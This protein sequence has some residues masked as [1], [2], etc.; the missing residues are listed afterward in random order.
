MAAKALF[1]GLI[2]DQSGN[3]V[4]TNF[5]GQDATYV[6]NDDG[7]H[8]HIDAEKIDRNI[9]SIFIEQLQNNRDLAVDQAM[10][11]MGKDDIFTKAAVDS[12]IDTVDM[13]EILKQGIP[14]Q[15]RN[16]MGMMGFK[17]VID[18]HGDIV[19]INQPAITDEDEY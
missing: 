14:A 1:D 8:R 12:S 10:K 7:F 15:A 9:L 4:G 5:V 17:I 3:L 6:I 19:D 2:Y 16:M 18:F 11:M 13:D